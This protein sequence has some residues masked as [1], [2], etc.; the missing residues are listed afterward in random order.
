MQDCSTG[1]Q[2]IVTSSAFSGEKKSLFR[3]QIVNEQPQSDRIEVWENTEILK[4][5]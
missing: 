4:K 3:I 2:Q 5:I 1:D